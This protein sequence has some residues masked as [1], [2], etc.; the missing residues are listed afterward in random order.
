MGYWSTCVTRKNPP[1]NFLEKCSVY[2]EQK[3]KILGGF[4]EN[5]EDGMWNHLLLFISGN[6]IPV[7]DSVQ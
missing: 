4:Y 6:C 2:I 3:I 5:H 7:L 1:T